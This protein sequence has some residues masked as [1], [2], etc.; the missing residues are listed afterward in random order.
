MPR[1]LLG[2]SLSLGGPDG[3]FIQIERLLCHTAEGEN[4]HSA[5]ANGNAVLPALGGEL[6]FEKVFTHSKF[7]RYSKQ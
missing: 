2:V 1:I 5:V 6:G 3:F 4:A 7:L